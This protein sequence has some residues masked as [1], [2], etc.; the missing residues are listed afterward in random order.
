MPDTRYCPKCGEECGVEDRFCTSCRSELRATPSR[1][2]GARSSGGTITEDTGMGQTEMGLPANAVL[3]DRYKVL[4]LLGAGG[5]GRVYLAEDQKLGI[6]VAIKVLKDILTQDP[7]SVKR[8]ITEAK[9]SILLAHPNIVRLHN[10]EDGETTKFLVMEYVEGQ[11]LDDK[12]ANEG[13]LTEAETRRIASEVCEGLEHAHLKKV[14]HRDMKPGNVLLGKDGS[15]KISDFGL[16]RLCHDSIARLTSQLS[17][18]TLQYMSP[19]QLDGEISEW[20]DQYSVGV[21]LYEM[22]SGSPPF[23]TGDLPGQIRNKVPKPIEGISPEMNGIVRRCLEKDKEKRFASIHELRDEL[24]GT[25]QKQRNQAAEAE[26]RLEFTKASAISAFNEG[27]FADSIALWQQALASK[28]AD[29]MITEALQRAQQHLAEAQNKPEIPEEKEP[30]APVPPAEETGR[31]EQ[32]ETLKARGKQAFAEARFG[33]AIAAWQEALHLDPQDANLNQALAEARRQADFVIQEAE[34]KKAED[35]ARQWINDAVV[36]VNGLFQSGAYKEA[37]TLLQQALQHFPGNATLSEYLARVRARL[38]PEKGLVEPK[39]KKKVWT[40]VLVGVGAFI[41]LGII[42]NLIN[43]PHG[44]ENILGQWRYTA[45]DSK[46]ASS[47]GQLMINRSGENLE[48]VASAGYQMTDNFGIFHQ[49]VVTKTFTGTLKGREISADMN[50]VTITEN[51][52]TRPYS[53]PYDGLDLTV[54]E[55]GLSMD[56][57][58]SDQYKNTIRVR[59]YR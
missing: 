48:I 33:D 56:G 34:R 9:T 30:E 58:V 22:L 15:I 28:P 31:L 13:K 45:T 32:I 59:V 6:P 27:R 19:E 8:L 55:D 54:S 49:F 4:K 47:V 44:T 29:P 37:E 46:G 1:P 50:A 39:S 53:D 20:S 18:G 16:A 17:T 40:W 38:I 7:A 36:R 25:A 5:M 52:I 21:M 12:I 10:F 35:A 43:R 14:I 51:G 57:E 11:T 23:V 42:G 2:G 41:I 24:D 26:Q 3:L